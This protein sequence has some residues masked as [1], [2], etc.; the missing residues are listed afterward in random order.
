MAVANEAA[1]WAQKIKPVLHTPPT[2]IAWKIISDH[3]HPDVLYN[4]DGQEGLVE[5]KYI[6]AY[7]A[8]ETTTLKIDVTPNQRNRLRDWVLSRGRCYV[9]L[10]VCNDWFL[11]PHTVPDELFRTDLTKWSLAWGNFKNLY[12]LRPLLMAPYGETAGL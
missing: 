3:G 1:F 4:Q 6:K 2:H 9:L 10:G 11:M 12:R 7:P 8:R 5:L